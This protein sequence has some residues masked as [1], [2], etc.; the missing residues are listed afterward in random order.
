MES[1]CTEARIYVSCDGYFYVKY[2]KKRISQK[3]RP[4]I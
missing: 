1:Q 4:V 3:R 2:T